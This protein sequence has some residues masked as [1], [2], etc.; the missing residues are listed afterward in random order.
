M[1]DESGLWIPPISLEVAP[2]EYERQVVE[3]LRS[4]KRSITDFRVSHQMQLAGAAGEYEF[5]AV[6]EFE[7]LEGARLVVLIECK[8]HSN[9]IKR[10]YI[11]ALE[12]KIR[13]VGAHKGMVFSTAGFQRGAINY[14]TERGIATVTFVDGSL[15]YV[16]RSRGDRAGPPSWSNAPEYAGL[17]F[18]EEKGTI[19]CSTLSNRYVK[20]LDDWLCNGVANSA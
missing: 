5:D 9:P 20:A 19:H 8:R 4:T 17:L 10:D 13:D 3:W 1:G 11:I 14:A 6:A 16:T 2:E 7:I 15:T 18:S 12:G